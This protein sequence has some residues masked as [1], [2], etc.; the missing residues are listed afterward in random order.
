MTYT[1]DG[2]DDTDCPQTRIERVLASGAVGGL[3]GLVFGPLG[4]LACTVIGAVV[5]YATFARVSRP[6][7]PKWAA[8]GKTAFRPY[9][10][11]GSSPAIGRGTDREARACAASEN[12]PSICGRT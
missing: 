9:A 12:P 5:G 11:R 7:A 1:R 8:L 3:I 10:G 4:T 6:R 2:W